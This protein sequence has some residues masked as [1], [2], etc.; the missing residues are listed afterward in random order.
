VDLPTLVLCPALPGHE[1]TYDPT[2]VADELLLADPGV[3]VVVPVVPD[4]L[5]GDDA[6]TTRAHW[7]AHLAIA[8]TAAQVSTPLVL[9]V[10]GSAGATVPAL[11]LS[12]RASRR[13]VVGYVLLDAAMP[14]S[15]G[16]E[17][18][19]DAPVHVVASPYAEPL[20]VNQARLRGW[21]VHEVADLEPAT[22]ASALVRLVVP[23]S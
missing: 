13:S 9:V 8:L 18:W 12:Q 23:T 19:P 21:T 22:L 6:R 11:G 10:S 14:T 3:A 17:D 7:V 1:P 5:P 2:A 16:V 20:E 15:D 4:G